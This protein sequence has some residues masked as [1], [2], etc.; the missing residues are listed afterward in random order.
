MAVLKN[1]AI[2]FLFRYAIVFIVLIDKNLG[3]ATVKTSDQPSQLVIFVPQG[4]A[5]RIF[6]ADKQIAV[7]L[8]GNFASYGICYGDEFVFIPDDVHLH[9]SGH[10][11]MYGHI[12]KIGNLHLYSAKKSVTYEIAPLVVSAFDGSRRITRYK[13]CAPLL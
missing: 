12:A 1:L 5:S 13:P 2:P 7:V 6:N 10:G 3:A 9:P 8:V 4:A 11:N